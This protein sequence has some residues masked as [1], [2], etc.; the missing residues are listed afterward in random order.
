M[1]LS[2]A[3]RTF[4]FE[5]SSINTFEGSL[6]PVEVCV[7]LSSELS[8]NFTIQPVNITINLA[9]NSNGTLDGK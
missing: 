4:S 7:L 1:L 3:I 5:Q 6:S 2:A 9:F 8:A